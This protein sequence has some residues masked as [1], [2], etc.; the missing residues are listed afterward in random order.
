MV[1]TAGVKMHSNIYKLSSIN[2]ENYCENGNLLWYKQFNSFQN[3]KI[4]E[5]FGDDN[6]NV[7]K[8]MISLYDKV[9]NI[10]RKG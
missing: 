5:A 9:E 4:F 8:M 1:N 2:T 6:F 3:D 10:V 7:A